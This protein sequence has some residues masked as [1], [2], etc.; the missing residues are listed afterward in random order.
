MPAEFSSASCMSSKH[1]AQ[2]ASDPD[3]SVNSVIHN[4]DHL[5]RYRFG[6]KTADLIV[7]KRC[8]IYLASV[9][10]AGNRRYATVNINTFDAPESLIQEPTTVAYEGE[11]AVQRRGRRE[12]KWTPVLVIKEGTLANPGEE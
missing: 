11:T 7:C 3:S 2:A 8:G 9:F 6:L 1:R 12:A 10:Q 4:L 5:S